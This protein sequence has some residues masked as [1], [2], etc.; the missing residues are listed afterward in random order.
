MTSNLAVKAVDIQRQISNI[1]DDLNNHVELQFRPL[2]DDT[3]KIFSQ[4]SSQVKQYYYKLNQAI[5]APSYSLDY[6][7]AEGER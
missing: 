7:Y 4:F 1:E 2:D 6:E 5:S 3:E